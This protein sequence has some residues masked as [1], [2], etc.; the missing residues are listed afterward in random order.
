MSTD[1]APRAEQQH[2]VALAGGLVLGLLALSQLVPTLLALVVADGLDLTARV[3]NVVLFGGPMAVVLYASTLLVRHGLGQSPGPGV[4]ARSRTGRL[5]V[6]S[7]LIGLALVVLAPLAGLARHL[8]QPDVVV[9]G[10]RG[11]PEAAALL[12]GA[13]ASGAVALGLGVVALLRS[14]DRSAVVLLTVALGWV[15]TT[16]GVGEVLVPH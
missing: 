6:R 1:L 7:L 3:V 11:S 5:A 13:W 14:R 2:P 16:F 4:R 9:H 10:F 8:L 12:L 15:V